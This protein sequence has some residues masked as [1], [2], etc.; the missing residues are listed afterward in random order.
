M[1]IN[2]QTLDAAFKGFKTLFNDAFEA[3][4]SHLD[5]LAMRAPSNSREEIYGWIGQ[6]PGLREW[7]GERFV[8]NLSAHGYAIPNKKFESTVSVIRDDISDDRLGIYKPMFQEMGRSAKMHPD[9]VVFGL[10]KKAF[11]TKCYD[12]QYFFDADHTGYVENGAG[13]DEVSVSNMQAGTDPAWF[14]FD[15]S[16]AVKPI[17]WQER[18]PYYFQAQNSDDSDHVFMKDEYRYGVRARCNAGF[19]LWQLAFGSKADLIPANYE[20][21]REAMAKFT[22]DQGQ[23]LAIVPTLMVVPSVL[24]A[25]A[26]KLLLADKLENGEANIWK[27]S[28]EL[29]VTPWLG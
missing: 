16:R 13:L 15:T 27:D 28:V 8:K 3:A 1:I 22:G 21:A 10:L 14:L 24:E 19:G 11:E 6:F 18:E 17:I 25:K 20:A 2:P 26:R 23:M 29:V 9:T 12:G 7:V 5:K 4:P